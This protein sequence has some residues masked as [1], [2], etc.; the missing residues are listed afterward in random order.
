MRL[1]LEL[2]H[3][4]RYTCIDKRICIFRVLGDQV[5]PRKREQNNGHHLMSPS[6]LKK[7]GDETTQRSSSSALLD[8]LVRRLQ[9]EQPGKRAAVDSPASY[10]ADCQVF[11][12]N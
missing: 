10:R 7:I 1:F 4:Y 12:F 5:S 8:P 9:F 2:E 6:K 3:R 11:F